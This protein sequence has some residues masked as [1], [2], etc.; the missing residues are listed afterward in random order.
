MKGVIKIFVI[1]N[2]PL[3]TTPKFVNKVTSG[4]PLRMG[5]SC[6]V[7]WELNRD[8]RVG[9]SDLLGGKRDG[10]RLNQSF[11]ASDL[12]KSSYVRKPP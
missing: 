10:G 1:H 4:K 3:S 8:Y 7:A 11:M 12:I 9:T 5:A 6:L 2:K